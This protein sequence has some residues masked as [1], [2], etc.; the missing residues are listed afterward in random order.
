MSSEIKEAFSGLSNI[1]FAPVEFLRLFDLSFQ[2]GSF[3]HL[4]DPNWETFMGEIYSYDMGWYHVAQPDNPDLHAEIGEFHEVLVPSPKS[5]EQH[6]HNCQRLSLSTAQAMISQKMLEENPI[7]HARPGWV[8]NESAFELVSPYI[9]PHFI[10]HLKIE[11]DFSRM[12]GAA[13][14]VKILETN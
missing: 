9:D 5:L 7:I 14:K 6:Y 8:L 13:L 2:K 3:D 12:F 4:A 10:S 11:V 1:D